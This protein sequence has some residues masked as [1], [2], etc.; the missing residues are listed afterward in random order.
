MKDIAIYGAGG[1]GREVA[2]LI[3]KINESCDT[4]I[5]NFIGFFDDNESLKSTCN[6]YGK[7]LG[8]IRELNTWDRPL[9]IVIAIGTPK[10]LKVVVE[11]IINPIIEFPNIIAPNVDLLDK[12]SIKLGKGNIICN[13]SEL[14]C[15][16]TL[17]NF[18]L[19]NVFTQIGHDTIIGN[20][21]IIMPSVNISGGCIVGDCNLFGVK[22]TVLQY[23]KI[24]NNVNIT[25]GSV[26]MRNGKDEKT[27]L[28]NPAKIFM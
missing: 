27:Y 12:S 13:K 5:W 18:N 21:N 4:P 16:I 9:A 28:G 10:V 14:S 7:I 24:G 23:K 19:L 15:N 20:F 8:G 11:K 22:S 1:F 2:C 6:L 26:M 17:G 25:P 3:K